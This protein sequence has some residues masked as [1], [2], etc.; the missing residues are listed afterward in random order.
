MSPEQYSTLVDAWEQHRSDYGGYPYDTDAE[1][2][3]CDVLGQGECD[4]LF[5]GSGVSKT[6]G[7]YVIPG[8]QIDQWESEPRYGASVAG[9]KAAIEAAASEIQTLD[10]WRNGNVYGGIVVDLETGE[11]DSC[12]G[13]ITDDL[14]ADVVDSGYFE[15]DEVFGG[16]RPEVLTYSQFKARSD[17]DQLAYLRGKRTGNPRNIRRPR[18]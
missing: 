8:E 18:R 15:F 13:F 2:I 12:Y 6:D 16:A 7:Y 5:G 9:Q 11:Q 3:F 17:S 1:R 10:L 14:E 4:A